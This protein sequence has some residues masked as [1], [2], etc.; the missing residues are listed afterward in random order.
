MTWTTDEAS[1]SR[2]DYGTSPTA[3]TANVS[4]AAAV[5]AHSVPLTGLTPGSTYHYR[6]RS[7]DA[8]GNATT[9]PV[10]A[11]PPATFAVPLSAAP[12]TT[13]I[14]TG[15]FRAGS[16]A[17]LTADDNVYYRVNTTTSGTR[18]SSWY[19]SFTGVPTTLASL[20]AT[21]V[22]RN[23][24][25]CTQTVA[26]WRWTDSTWQQMDSRTVGN[27]DVT[28]ANLVPPGAASGY[29]SPTGEVRVRVRCTGTTTGFSSGDLMTI[30]YARP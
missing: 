28:L 16:A 14:E 17:A 13:V 29:V 21:Y 11:D 7:S 18:I 12:A 15:T 2:V 30:T 5:T 19:G 22:G 4:D 25:S 1:D 24:R 26:A 20:R 3:L 6:V 9:S 10:A 8:S 23:R 27:A